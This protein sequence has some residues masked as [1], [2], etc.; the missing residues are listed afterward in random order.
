MR[1]GLIVMTVLLAASTTAAAAPAKG[2]AQRL[3]DAARVM[4]E[5]RSTP[6]N[7][8]PAAIWDRARCV[9][10]MPGLK[11]AEFVV[12]GEYGRGVVSCRTAQGWSAPMFLTLEKASVGV[13]LGAQST[14]LV[15][16]VMNDGG[17]QRLEQD[18]VTLGADASLAAGPIGRTSEAATDAQLTAEIL[19]YSRTRG[20]FAGID[21]SGGV[22]RPDER[23]DRRFYG[24]PMVARD[25][26][27]GRAPHETPMAANRFIA[28]LNRGA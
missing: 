10:V 12:G 21:L 1:N 15:L 22:L 26:L 16:L 4:G 8:I 5:L 24:Q 2:E 17:M 9:A 13:Q 7:G 11:K 20:V 25:L 27:A 23:A 28:A 14:D 3:A 6:D 18:R 19:S